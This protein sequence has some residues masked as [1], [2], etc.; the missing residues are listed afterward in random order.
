M[1][2]YANLIK[3]ANNLIKLFV[4]HANAIFADSDFGNDIFKD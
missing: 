4:L 1:N 3:G 2:I